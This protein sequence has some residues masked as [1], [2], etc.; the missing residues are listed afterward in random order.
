MD[1][2]TNVDE[3]LDNLPDA[4]LDSKLEEKSSST[5]E[6]KT[7]DEKELKRL[8]ENNT[9]LN[10]KCSTATW[11]KRYEKWAE[12]KGEQTDLAKVS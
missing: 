3:F 5:S 9:N 1:N 12:H 10:T 4:I 8:V 2:G 6:F 11:L 7:T